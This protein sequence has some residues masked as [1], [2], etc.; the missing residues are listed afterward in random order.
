[1]NEISLGKVVGPNIKRVREERGWRR[2][3]L[4]RRARQIGLSW[5][6]HVLANVETGRKQ[7]DAGELILLTTL[8]EVPVRELLVCE[9]SE[10]VVLENLR[11][12]ADQLAAMADGKA[13]RRE[14]FREETERV[15]PQLEPEDRDLADRYGLGDDEALIA[16]GQVGYAEE[17]AAKTL[18]V[19]PR[20]VAF[21][22]TGL[23]GSSLGARRDQEAR[24]DGLKGASAAARRGHVTR[25]LVEELAEYIESRDMG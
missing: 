23:W 19:S 4:V 25:G 6:R 14:A 21:A 17:A 22:A 5:T 18:D 15:I 3:E 9:S 1:M 8:L 10:V 13:Y 2:D 7:I 11:V 12:P 24:T 20:E 16:R